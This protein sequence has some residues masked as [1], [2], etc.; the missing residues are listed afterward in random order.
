MSWT[1][2]LRKN[3]SF[4]KKF[5]SDSISISVLLQEVEIHPYYNFW[6]YNNAFNIIKHLLTTYY[7]YDTVLGVEN[8]WMHKTLRYLLLVGGDRPK[9]TIYNPT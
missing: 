9:T 1:L 8:P 2:K 4:E 7:I 6:L 5:D 3:N